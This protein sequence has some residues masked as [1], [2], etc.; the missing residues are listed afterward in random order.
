MVS[1]RET[2]KGKGFLLEKFQSKSTKL[3]EPS[4]Y[5]GNY[6]YLNSGYKGKC[7][8][9]VAGEFCEIKLFVLCAMDP[10]KSFKLAITQLICISE[11][12][13]S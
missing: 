4:V 13:L 2:E 11:E 5:P 12:V 8:K 10:L 3:G 7:R 6:Q 9:K 1:V